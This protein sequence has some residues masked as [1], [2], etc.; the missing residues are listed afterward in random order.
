MAYYPL[1][2]RDG[3]CPITMIKD[4]GMAFILPRIFSLP[5][6]IDALNKTP[7]SY[8]PE[9]CPQPSCRHV[10]IWCH[11]C[12]TRKPA[13][14]DPSRHDTVS[15]PR[16]YCPECRCTC[17]ALPEYIPPRGRYLWEVR[18]IV[19]LLLLAGNSIN[20]THASNGSL[21]TRRTI[22]RWWRDFNDRDCFVNFS[23]HLR[24]H[25][26]CMGRHDGFSAFWRGCLSLRP[27]STVMRLLHEDGVCVP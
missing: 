4:N 13:G 11:G 16:F 19:F 6:H 7:E 22:K 2:S 5:Q 27:L 24:L 15:I 25:L 3:F 26:P 21:A 20:R 1:V 14:L 18:Q 8:R 9:R 12:Y 17:S 10:G 23:L